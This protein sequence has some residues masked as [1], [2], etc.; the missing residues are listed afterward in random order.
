MVTGNNAGGF[1]AVSRW[2]G[3]ETHKNKNSAH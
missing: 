2:E 3:G 1:E